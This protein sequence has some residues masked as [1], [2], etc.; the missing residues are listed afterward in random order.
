[1]AASAGSAAPPAGEWDADQILA[2]VSLVNAASVAAVSAVA[3]G[4][5][6]TYDNRIA[7]DT[8]TIGRLITL[9]GGNAGLRDRIRVHGDALCALAGAAL[10]ETELAT[11]VPS[12]LRSH[13]SAPP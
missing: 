2:H 12:R 7:S 11:P 9:A 5:N 6:T 8:W 13:G 1:M 4:V 10:S 3:S